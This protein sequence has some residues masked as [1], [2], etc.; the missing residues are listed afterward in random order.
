ML[1]ITQSKGTCAS[2][3]RKITFTYPEAIKR[4]LFRSSTPGQSLQSQVLNLSPRIDQQRRL[5]NTNTPS[6][7]PSPQ[8]GESLSLPLLGGVA[9]GSPLEAQYAN[10]FF[11]VPSAMVKEPTKTFALKVKGDSMIEDGIFDGDTVLVESRS[12]VNK[13]EIAVAVVGEEATIKRVFF[14]KDKGETL[15]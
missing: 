12:R 3:K 11:D 15:R 7:A 5:P 4:G 10:E 1:L 13:G 14:H 9:A 2:W 8:G 6:E